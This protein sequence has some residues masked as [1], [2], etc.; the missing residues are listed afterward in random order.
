MG[1]EKDAKAVKRKR[2]IPV[3]ST[4]VGLNDIIAGC[5]RICHR[6]MPDDETGALNRMKLCPCK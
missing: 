1:T 4:T 6:I 2:I 5:T 3:L